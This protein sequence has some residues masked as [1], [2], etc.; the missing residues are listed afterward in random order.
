MRYHRMVIEGA[1]QLRRQGI[2]GPVTSN[3]ASMVWG[4]RRRKAVER[5]RK[6]ER[7]GILKASDTRPIRWSW[8]DVPPRPM[9]GPE[10]RVYRV[11]RDGVPRTVRQ[12]AEVAGICS[13]GVRT[14]L[15]SMLDG[16]E[17]L[18]VFIDEV[19]DEGTGRTAAVYQETEAALRSI[20]GAA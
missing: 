12:I 8:V 10:W 14:S 13:T 1:V 17:P 4:C 5:L 20:L 19:T 2:T 7:Y 9:T 6:M 3:R 15:P 16:K 18:L 11:M